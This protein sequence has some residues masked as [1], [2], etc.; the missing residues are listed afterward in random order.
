[1]IVIRVRFDWIP[2]TPEWRGAIR[3]SDGEIWNTARWCEACLAVGYDHADIDAVLEAQRLGLD[4]APHV[5]ECGFCTAP[6]CDGCADQ[7]RTMC[8]ACYHR[9]PGA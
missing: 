6:P 9:G 8:L 5:T 1:M 7:T 3:A 2:S 4:H